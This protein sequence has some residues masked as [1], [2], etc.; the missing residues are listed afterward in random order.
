MLAHVGDV[1]AP[2]GLKL[3][4]RCLEIALC[5]LKLASRCP[6]W[7][8]KVSQVPQDEAKMALRWFQNWYVLASWSFFRDLLPDLRFPIYLCFSGALKAP[9]SVTFWNKM[10]RFLCRFWH[11]G[12]CM[13]K[14]VSRYPHDCCR[15]AY[16]SLS[17]AKLAPRCHKI[18]LWWLKLDPRHPKWPPKASQVPQDEAKMAPRW[19]RNWYVLA[20][21]SFFCGLLPDLRFSMFSRFSGPLKASFLVNF[22]NKIRWIFDH[23]GHLGSC[24]HQEA[25]R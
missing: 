16:L 21:W 10:R 4:P 11:L 17:G 12:L 5:W 24:M 7:P 14:E 9:I 8:L 18:A 23:F 15:M 19:L 13:P 25:S 2:G 20:S 1:L 3:A 6:K 22:W